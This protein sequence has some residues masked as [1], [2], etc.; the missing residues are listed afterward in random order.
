M[1]S[2]IEVSLFSP[3]FKKLFQKIILIDPIDPYTRTCFKQEMQAQD[4]SN[5]Q[6]AS[7]QMRIE[8][9]D[10]YLTGRSHSSF[11][12][13]F[14]PGHLILID[15][16]DPFINNAMAASLFEIVVEVFLETS[17]DTGKILREFL[18]SA[19]SLSLSPPSAMN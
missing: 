6:R 17:I 7:F 13:H 8:M 5:D 18:S 15:L 4:L 14:K 19:Y 1:D 11:Q 12:L 16:R 2:A 9:L 3:S 10:S